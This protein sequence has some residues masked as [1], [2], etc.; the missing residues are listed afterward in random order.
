MKVS[1]AL[2][3]STACW[4]VGRKKKSN[5]YFSLTQSSQH[6]RGRLPGLIQPFVDQMR[7]GN[8][9]VNASRK[10]FDNIYARFHTFYRMGA[11]QER[12]AFFNATLLVVTRHRRCIP[13]GRQVDGKFTLFSRFALFFIYD[14][15]GKMPA[16]IPEEPPWACQK[17]TVHPGIR[18]SRTSR[19]HNRPKDFSS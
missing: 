9:H 6:E 5:G 1:A 13:E 14:Q 12:A 8:I 2:K 19:Y 10:T 18:K 3:A 11:S 7:R 16:Y 4:G 15:D 17:R